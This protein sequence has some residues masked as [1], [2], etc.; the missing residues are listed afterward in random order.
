MSRDKNG[1][2]APLDEA[3]R[4]KEMADVKKVLADCR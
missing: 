4:A 3:Q 2:R 1:E